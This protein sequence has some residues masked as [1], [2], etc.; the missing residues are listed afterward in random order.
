MLNVYAGRESSMRI[1][2]TMWTNDSNDDA[3]DDAKD[4]DPVRDIHQPRMHKHKQTSRPH[5]S[6]RVNFALK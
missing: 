5:K 2:T 4:D 6:N 1:T 3:D